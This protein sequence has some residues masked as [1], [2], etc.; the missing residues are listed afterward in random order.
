MACKIHCLIVLGT[1]ILLSTEN[2]M[3]R[4]YNKRWMKMSRRFLNHE[5]HPGRCALLCCFKN[6]PGELVVEVL[7]KRDLKCTYLST[8]TFE[9]I[10]S[11]ICSFHLTRLYGAS[12]FPHVQYWAL[13]NQGE[14]DRDVQSYRDFTLKTAVF[15]ASLPTSFWIHSKTKEEG[16][17]EMQISLCWGSAAK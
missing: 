14:Q 7:S 15:K 1:L 16:K 13:K 17:I 12:F 5:K 3:L 8:I 4:R 9:T 6:K 2:R 11:F 10:H